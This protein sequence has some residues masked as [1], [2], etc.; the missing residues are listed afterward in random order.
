MVKVKGKSR[1]FAKPNLMRFNHPMVKVKAE[2]E[3]YYERIGSSFNHPMVKVKVKKL[4]M[5]L[6]TLVSTTL[7]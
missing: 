1:F 5:M 4:L 2:K 6:L 7:W 3:Y